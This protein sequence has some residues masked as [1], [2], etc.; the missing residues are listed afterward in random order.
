[1]KKQVVGAAIALSFLTLSGCQTT[2]SNI[3][4]GGA[5]RL[6]GDWHCV[7][8]Y[9]AE[10]K[11]ESFTTFK[12][13]YDSTG[14][15]KLWLSVVP[16][17]PDAEFEFVHQGRWTMSASQVREEIVDYSLTAKNDMA[18]SIKPMVQ[19]LFDAMLEPQVTEILELTDEKFV[20]KS[21]TSNDTFSCDRIK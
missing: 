8:S 7:A 2:S 20:G 11:V 21:Y 13:T 16:G 3:A 6:V 5:E 14:I 9:G 19:S 15:T 17:K 1:M 10:S 12:E 4:N 18:H